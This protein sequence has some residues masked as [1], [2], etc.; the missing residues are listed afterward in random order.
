MDIDD[1]GQGIEF[2]G[3]KWKGKTAHAVEQEMEKTG[4]VSV[5]SY[6]PD[7][8]YLASRLQGL[9]RNLEAGGDEARGRRWLDFG[10]DV[11]H[12]ADDDAKYAVFFIPR[13]KVRKSFRRGIQRTWQKSWQPSGKRQPRPWR[14]GGPPYAFIATATEL[15]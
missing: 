9:Q 5:M 6:A 1:D 2:A 4:D 14:L 12:H 7:A 8:V 11:E 3:R 15:Y 10:D 13:A